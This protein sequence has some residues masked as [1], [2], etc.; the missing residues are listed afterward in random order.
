MKQI[1]TTS[2]FECGK[3]FCNH[4]C[5]SERILSALAVE[6][7]TESVFTVIGIKRGRKHNGTNN[8]KRRKSVDYKR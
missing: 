5:R 1:L 8:T 3:L 2:N 6:I 7:L 4:W